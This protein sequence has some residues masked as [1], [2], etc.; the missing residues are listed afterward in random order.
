MKLK[1]T[2][3]R[4]NNHCAG[5]YRPG[6]LLKWSVEEIGKGTIGFQMWILCLTHITAISV[7]IES[8]QS[9]SHECWNRHRCPVAGKP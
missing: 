6:P 5:T 9:R 1:Q 8:I 7:H 3:G 2:A 4:V